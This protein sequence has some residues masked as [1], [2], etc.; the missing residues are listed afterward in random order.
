LCLA[1]GGGWDAVAAIFDHLW[2]DGH[3]GTTAAELEEVGRR[4]GLADVAAA[5]GDEAVK[6]VLRANTEAA[7]ARGVFGVPMLDAGGQLFWGDDATGMIED[8]LADPARFD[9]GEYAR[10]AALPGVQRA[11]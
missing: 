6:S 7:L 5:T 10:I 4:L 9:S 3:A 11:R 8:W 2:R 1:A